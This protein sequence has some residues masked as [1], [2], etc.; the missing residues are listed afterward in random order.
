MCYTAAK[1]HS[2]ALCV[3]T[4]GFSVYS[5]QGSIWKIYVSARKHVRGIS[6]ERKDGKY[7]DGGES[8]GC[9][10]RDVKKKKRTRERIKQLQGDKEVW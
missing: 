6:G 3:C 8:K 4:I 7:A 5:I 9:D 10:K 1:I 2:S